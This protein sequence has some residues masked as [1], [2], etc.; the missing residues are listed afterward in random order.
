M[1]IKI[2]GELFGIL[3]SSFGIIM[4]LKDSSI[5]KLQNE[6]VTF[7]RQ[8]SDNVLMAK[9]ATQKLSNRQKVILHQNKDL[10]IRINKVCH[11][12]DDKLNEIRL[13]IARLDK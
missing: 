12:M 4:T 6:L 2:L 10:N 9:V 13:D 11:D 3:V 1:D 7:K 5:G 8:Y